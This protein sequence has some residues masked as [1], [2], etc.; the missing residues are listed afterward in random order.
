MG[1]KHYTKIASTLTLK[2]LLKMYTLSYIIQKGDSAYG[3][4]IIQNI[5][6]KAALW[7]PS[8]SSLYPLLVS[9]V[10]GKEN[11]KDEPDPEKMLL[12]IAEEE[13]NRK[14]YKA[15]EAGEKY[16]K[17]ASKD[18]LESLKLTSDFYNTVARELA[19][20]DED[21]NLIDSYDK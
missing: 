8:H 11:N 4:E 19:K 17:D 7:S 13:G 18:F 14:Y 20:F 10:E 16:Y 1:N 9:M 5:Q 12:Y 15:T 21:G 6:S 3:R 2:D